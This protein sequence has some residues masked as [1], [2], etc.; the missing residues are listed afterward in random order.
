MA[1]HS[2]NA[3][4]CARS[5]LARAL[6][7]LSAMNLKSA[8]LVTSAIASALAL[9]KVLTTYVPRALA[10]PRLRLIRDPIGIQDHLAGVLDRADGD[11]ARPRSEAE[12]LAHASAWSGIPAAETG[13][14]RS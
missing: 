3:R 9:G 6:Q 12:A 4:I 14:T 10:K 1:K 7:R 13:S 8:T 2:G 5:M 11:Q